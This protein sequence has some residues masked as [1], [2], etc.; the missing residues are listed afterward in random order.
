VRLSDTAFEIGMAALRAET[1]SCG[2]VTLNVDLFV[3]R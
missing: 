2:P 3:F 1:G